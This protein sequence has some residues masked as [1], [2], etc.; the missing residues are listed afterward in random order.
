LLLEVVDAVREGVDGRL[1][2]TVKLGTRD[3]VPDGLAREDAMATAQALE[4]AGVAALEVSAGLT[5]AKLESAQQ[6]TAV[7]RRRAAQD[8]LVHRLLAATPPQ[9]YFVSEARELKRLLG[10]PVIL[11]GGL[12]TVE[13]MEAVIAEGVADFVSLGRPLIREPGLVRTIEAGRTGLV[14]CTSCNICMMHEGVHSLRC[15]RLS[16]RRLA[17]HAWYRLTGRLLYK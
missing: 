2:V 13:F 1:P 3:F 10:I 11:V 6:Y 14:D 8:K 9:G 4:G 12:R 17:T 7:T 5:T 16:T 15:W